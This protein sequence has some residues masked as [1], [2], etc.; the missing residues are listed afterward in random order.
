MWRGATRTHWHF[1]DLMIPFRSPTDLEGDDERHVDALARDA[2]TGRFIGAAHALPLAEEALR[3]ARAKGY[4]LGEARALSASA[5]IHLKLLDL[6]R[7]LL[8]AT[9]ATHIFQ[10]LGEATEYASARTIQG[11]V[12]GRRGEYDE[13]L[14]H[15]GTCYE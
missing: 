10:S 9:E 4:Q 2:Y 12:H 1:V 14:R 8:E 7:A 5:A 3:I 15:H 11:T 6:D 13:A